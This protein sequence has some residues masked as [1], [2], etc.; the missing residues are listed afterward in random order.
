MPATLQ[1]RVLYCCCGTETTEDLIHPLSPG[2]LVTISIIDGS[3]L[4]RERLSVSSATACELFPIG[5]CHVLSRGLHLDF[6]V[7]QRSKLVE[8]WGT[9]KE[10][11]NKPHLNVCISLADSCSAPQTTTA[12]EI[13][14]NSWWGVGRRRVRQRAA[15]CSQ[16]RPRSVVVNSKLRASST[17]N[18]QNHK[19]KKLTRGTLLI[20]RWLNRR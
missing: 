10:T 20:V 18:S 17:K 6:E 4:S 2:F 5:R 3:C 16:K 11:K 15:V 14:G 13:E 8:I 12:R 19:K 7:L 9:Q 1:I